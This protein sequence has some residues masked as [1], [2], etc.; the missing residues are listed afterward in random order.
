[1]RLGSKL[2]AAAL[3]GA[4]AMMMATAPNTFAKTMNPGAAVN[5]VTGP[6]NGIGSPGTNAPQVKINGPYS[7]AH[8]AEGNDLVNHQATG[9]RPMPNMWTRSNIA[10][11]KNNHPKKPSLGNGR[12]DSYFPGSRPLTAHPETPHSDGVSPSSNMTVD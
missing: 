7:P 11:P 1:M 4:F 9:T 3:S 12:P 10:N 6:G 2:T 8:P 5:S